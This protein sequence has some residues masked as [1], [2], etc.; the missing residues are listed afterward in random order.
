MP[1]DTIP[2]RDLVSLLVSEAKR[3]ILPMAVIFGLVSVGVLIGGLVMPKRW[4]A[5]TL[6]VSHGKDIIKQ[7]LDGR[8][9]PTTITDQTSVVTQA[10]VSRPILREIAAFGGWATHPLSLTEED[11]LL[12][13]IKERIKIETQKDET[14]I[15]ISYYDS[16]PRRA[17]EITN[18]LAEI[19]IRETLALK[20]AQSH[21]AFDFIS[22][23]VKEYAEKMSETHGK[24]LAYYRGDGAHIKAPIA[25]PKIAPSPTARDEEE[26]PRA[27]ISPEELDALRAEE[28]TLKAQLG[29]KPAPLTA[30]PDSHFAEEQYRA[31][32]LQQQ[33]ELDRLRE[34][35]TEQ[36]PDVL[37]AERELETAKAELSRA[38]QLRTAHEKAVATAVALDDEVTRGAAARLDEI[39]QKISVATGTPRV[40]TIKPGPLVVA[41]ESP[42][43]IEMRSVGQDTVLSELLRRYEATRDVYQDLL[44]RQENARV[45][46]DLDSEHRGLTVEVK[47]PAEIPV[48]SSSIRLR[49]IALI[50]LAFAV[51]VPL[52]LLFGLIKLDPR[53]RSSQ[54]IEQ[55]SRL[56]LLVTIPSS[57]T[58]KAKMRLRTQ[59]VLAASIV[60]GV[61]VIYAAIF[62]VKMQSS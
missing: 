59:R 6:I 35:Y 43:D 49:D 26:R 29:R 41:P 36:H 2:L 45:S 60:V 40:R 31:R 17:Y 4:E 22:R 16:N 21:D 47:E 58:S 9:V 25:A 38:D 24:V 11:R 13:H 18:K 61:F 32:V 1:P 55:F 15:R 50:G 62:V 54:Q 3:R 39:Q 30:V 34:R 19:F 46:M 48:V 8:A 27:H 12:K 23:R 51:L 37:H 52:G 44:K 14:A 53:V 28:A 5:S 56:P 42:A 10:M 33:V 57:T 20:E 7:L